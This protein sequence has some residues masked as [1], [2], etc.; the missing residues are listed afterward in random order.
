MI[1]SVILVT[2]MSGFN[3]SDRLCAKDVHTYMHLCS[4]ARMDGFYAPMDACMLHACMYVLMR[5]CM[6]G[7]NCLV[8]CQMG[9]KHEW[10]QLQQSW[11]YFYTANK[12]HHQQCVPSVEACACQHKTTSVL[13]IRRCQQ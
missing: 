6:H 7:L 9:E 3:S 5:V 2:C 8:S 4:Y 12:V 13:E 11:D 1:S 10:D